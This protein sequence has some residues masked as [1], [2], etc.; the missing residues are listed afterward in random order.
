MPRNVH[1][2]LHDLGD[3]PPLASKRKG[4]PA[5]RHHLTNRVGR[6][7]EKY[8]IPSGLLASIGIMP[9]TKRVPNGEI[10]EVGFPPVADEYNIANRARHADRIDKGRERSDQKY[11]RG[12]VFFSLMKDT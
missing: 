8:R 1:Q 2:T 4:P 3:Y 6:T 12:F 5:R 9:S 11:R 7:Y 10:A